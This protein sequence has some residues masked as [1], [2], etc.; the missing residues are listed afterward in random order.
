M[1][2]IMEKTIKYLKRLYWIEIDAVANAKA[3]VFESIKQSN[4]FGVVQYAK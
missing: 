4:E 2:F 3:F 1:S